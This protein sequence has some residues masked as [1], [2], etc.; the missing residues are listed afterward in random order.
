MV[1]PS[2]TRQRATK[3]N[4][5]CT[6]VRVVIGALP[7]GAGVAK[8]CTPWLPNG[9][10]TCYMPTSFASVY[11]EAFGDLVE[12]PKRHLYSGLLAFSVN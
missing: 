12:L 2:Q 8:T 3:R 11:S 1:L 5:G 4:P 9:M 6:L 7:E 10:P